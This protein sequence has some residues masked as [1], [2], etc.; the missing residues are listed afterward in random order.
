MDTYRNPIIHA[1]Y[2][3]PDVICVGDDFYMVAS[4]FTYIPGVPILHSKDLVHWHIINHAV[5]S[6]PFDKYR[7]PSHGSG[8]WAPSIRYHEGTFYVFIP[9]VDEGIM[10]ARSKDIYG[11]FELNMLT[12]T[13]GWIDPCPLWDDDGRA[14]MFFAYARSRCGLK[15]KLMMIEIDS[16]CRKTIGK[17]R[18]IFDGTQTAHTCEGP[19]AYKKDGMYYIFFPAGSPLRASSRTV[20]VSDFQ[21]SI[22][23]LTITTSR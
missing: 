16:E 12:H 23:S 18:L 8:T 20:L 21:S 9:L 17:E 7:E 3:D 1:D 19:K 6:L 4:S 2:S 5:R 11:E 22:S 10:V 15:H 13:A 14:Y